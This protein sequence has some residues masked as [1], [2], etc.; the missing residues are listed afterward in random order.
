MSRTL[1]CLVVAGTLGL[2]FHSSGCQALKP[3]QAG[4]GKT[5]GQR[6]CR[7]WTNFGLDALSTG[8]LSQAKSFFTRATAENPQDQLARIN[9]ARA[10]RQEGDL[11]AAIAQMQQGLELGGT[12]DANLI[13]ELGDM[14]LQAGHSRMAQELTDAA[15]KIDHRCA[16]AWALQGHLQRVTGDYPAALESFQRAVSLN[17]ELSDLQ[18]EIAAMYQAQNQPLRAL[19]AIEKVLH[20]YP[21][22]QQ[23]EA[24]LL[25]KG[26]VLMQLQQFNTAIEVLQLASERNHPSQA[27]LVQL[28]E[29]QIQNKD[30]SQARLTLNRA[31]ELYPDQARY[32]G[33]L[34]KMADTPDGVVFR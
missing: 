26:E 3:F 19:S 31:I 14:H 34:V 24:A 11:P 2:V 16:A 9:L 27:V 33:L 17:P 23:P 1:R 29:A 20:R 10:L 30:F 8:K 25:A 6:L 7:Q 22:D 21:P 28:A 4:N 32:Q 15:L 18:L 12:K 13:S 5:M